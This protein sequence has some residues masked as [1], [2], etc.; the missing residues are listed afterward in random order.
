MVICRCKKRLFNGEAPMQVLK[1][2]EYYPDISQETIEALTIYICDFDVIKL[3][4]NIDLG[5]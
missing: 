4:G 1:S 3:A 2:L 5:L